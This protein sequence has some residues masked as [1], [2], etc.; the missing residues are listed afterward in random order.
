[1]DA[2]R[3]RQITELF[4]RVADVSE[5]D[6]REALQRVASK[7]PTLAAEVVSLF[8]D[9]AQLGEFLQDSGT[10]VS[11]AVWPGQFA[12]P[13][14]GALV[15]R[16]RIERRIGEGGAGLVFLARRADREFEQEVAIKVLKP[17]VTGP[18]SIARLRTERQI[19]AQLNHPAIAKLH[20]GGTTE[21]Q[22]P[23]VVMEL[24][25]GQPI[26]RH[27]DDRRTSL[28]QR[29]ILMREVC[30][31]VH[32][33]HQNLVV[34]RDLKPSN[35]LVTEDGRPKL[36]DFGIA[37]LLDPER[38]SPAREPTVHWLRPMTPSYA[39][40]EQIRGR[41][42]TTATDVYALGVLLYEL[43]TGR[44]P[45]DLSGKSLAEVERMICDQEPVRPSLVMAELMR[46]AASSDTA[47]TLDVLCRNRCASPKELVTSL[48]G[49][50]DRIVLCALHKD[51]G[52]R[53]ASVE[54]FSDDLRRHVAGLPVTVR[55]DS[56]GYRF[57]KFVRRNRLAAGLAATGIG[58]TLAWAISATVL[59]QRIAAERDSK[60]QILGYVKDVFQLADPEEAP[61]EQWTLQEALD[62]K[63]S[64]LVEELPDPAARAE[65]LG[66]FGRI[67]LSQ[68]QL[69]KSKEL[70]DQA[71]ELWQLMPE[72]DEAELI[73]TLVDF[74]AVLRELDDTES[75]LRW[76]EEAVRLARGFAA[77]AVADPG[78]Q[79]LITPLSELTS[80]LC[81]LGEFERAAEVNREVLGLTQ[82]LLAP[83]DR[84]HIAAVTTRAYISRRRGA[85]TAAIRDYRE[86]LRLHQLVSTGDQPLVADVLANLAAA[87][88]VEGSYDEA[89]EVGAAALAMRRRILPA[90]HTAIA[91]SLSNLAKTFEKQGDHGDAEAALVETLDILRHHASGS[92][93][94]LIST[95]TSLA[96]VQLAANQPQRIVESL[97]AM[98]AMWRRE[99]PR[100]VVRLAVAENLLGAAYLQLEQCSEARSLIPESTARLQAELGD[101]HQRTAQASERLTE[102]RRVCG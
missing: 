95:H 73:A 41:P 1:M 38:S 77:R 29:I 102:L 66:F 63:S 76:S 33:A 31:A 96:A 58:L 52:R 3:W 56:V 61:G 18:R 21:N 100:D 43:L 24:V 32:Y 47:A 78:R 99:R 94:R 88:H 7:D 93:P 62:R 44:L 4:D 70:L 37:K 46:E 48:R 101:Q 12:A 59:L 87:L 16:Y 68:G 53:Y 13:E 42:V 54:Q 55:G 26:D 8:I 57:G 60:E 67:Y 83:T 98:L 40:P 5:E 75:A 89:E 91:Q 90:N 92:H 65:L 20:D 9:E 85:L 27:C 51:P 25:K 71:R 69:F 72:P 50:L 81:Y 74:S 79:I 2:E 14:P 80:V 10:S 19:L 28:K 64:T 82:R 30:A 35:I 86:A 6:R 34:H 49:D 22:L 17:G 23:Y 84:Q 39:S 15:G 97:P 45:F 36:L 11:G